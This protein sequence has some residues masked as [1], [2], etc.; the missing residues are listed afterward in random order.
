M[1]S[2]VALIIKRKQVEE[3]RLRLHG[4]LLHADRLAT[5][6]MLAA[7]IAH[8]LNEPLGNF[9]VRSVGREMSGYSCCGPARH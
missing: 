4:Q 3:D 5:I 2:Q 1:A 7:G 9:R 6:G 8:E